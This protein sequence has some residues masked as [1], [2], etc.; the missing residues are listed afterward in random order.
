MFLL[1]YKFNDFAKVL[2]KF[3]K[4]LISQFGKKKPCS[5]VLRMCPSPST[6]PSSKELLFC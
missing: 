3:A 6:H 5:H 1:Y 2:E 4:F